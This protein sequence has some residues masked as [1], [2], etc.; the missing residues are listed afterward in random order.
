MEKREQEILVKEILEMFEEQFITIDEAIEVLI[1]ASAEVAK[2]LPR[3]IEK[4]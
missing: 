1:M 2:K 3:W 4:K